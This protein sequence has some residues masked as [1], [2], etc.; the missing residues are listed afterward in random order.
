MCKTKNEKVAFIGRVV[1][2]TGGTQ[3]SS[4]CGRY[5]ALTGGEGRVCVLGFGPN[6]STTTS[7]L[8]R[9]SDRT[10]NLI[11]EDLRDFD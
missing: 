4:R 11:Y 5:Y 9:L 7:D 6:G 10:V 2:E 3:L 1:G 8:R